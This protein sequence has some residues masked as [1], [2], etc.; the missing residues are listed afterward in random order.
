MSEVMGLPGGGRNYLAAGRLAGTALSDALGGSRWEACQFR[1]WVE[2][3]AV[4]VRGE[5]SR[6]SKVDRTGD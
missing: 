4:D 1:R 3:M 2:M 6:V 5:G